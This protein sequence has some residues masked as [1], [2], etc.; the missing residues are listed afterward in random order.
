MRSKIESLVSKWRAA[1]RG[2]LLCANVGDRVALV[3]A[4]RTDIAIKLTLLGLG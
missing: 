2:A 4:S 1:G 3:R